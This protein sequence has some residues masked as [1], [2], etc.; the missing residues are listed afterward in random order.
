MLKR[1]FRSQ[2]FMAWINLESFKLNWHTKI[3][4]TKFE[5]PQTSL[6]GKVSDIKGINLI[7]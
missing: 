1:I 5:T 4:F 7:K 3:L 6:A 2:D